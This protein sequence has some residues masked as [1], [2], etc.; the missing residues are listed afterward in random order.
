MSVALRPTPMGSIA[1]G[2]V[3]ARHAVPVGD[4][5]EVSL[6]ALVQ[7]WRRHW[8]AVAVALGLAWAAVGATVLQPREYSASIALAAVPNPK[9]AA[10]SGGISALLAAGQTGGLQA[11]PRFVA[12]LLGMR[13]VMLG[14]AELPATPGRAEKV[15]EVVARRP[16]ARI[17]PGEI[18]PA[19]R[20]VVT[21]DVD[22]NTGIV[23]L[24]VTLRDSAV[25]RRTALAVTAAAESQYRLVSRAQ[26]AQQRLAT[27]E[28]VDSAARQLRRAEERLADFIAGHRAYA[29]YADATIER[30]RIERDVANA[31][32]VN[33]QALQ[34][35]EQAIAHELEDTPALAVVDGVPATLVP[36][37]RHLAIKGFL[38]SALALCAV[39]A[40]LFVRG[41]FAAPRDR[42]GEAFA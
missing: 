26:A 9:T 10:L 22:K 21:N 11:T 34:D 40:W 39:G 27:A 38:A 14:V 29:A 3:P 42:R 5:A 13:G 35:R 16:R 41:E 7:P 36:T 24:T 17:A 15:I 32:V 30:T 4:G 18:E 19:M 31:N 37:P 25:A 28:R 2:G 23:T 6:S 8:R 12:A 33:T 1:V 20:E